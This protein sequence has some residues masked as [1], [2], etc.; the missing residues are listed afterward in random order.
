MRKVLF[1]I[2][3]FFLS[4]CFLDDGKEHYNLED[5]TWEWKYKN[6]QIR[7]SR[8]IVNGY[9]HGLQID[10]YSNG[11]YRF[12]YSMKNGIQDG[13]EYRYYENGILA[14]GGY[15]SNGKADGIY[16]GFYENG[17]PKFCDLFREDE[18]VDFYKD[19]LDELRCKDFIYGLKVFSYP[20]SD[21]TNS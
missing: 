12:I 13:P 16:Y 4:S 1:I 20:E 5:G 17:D 15:M 7:E 3:V 9:E 11:N 2:P 8:T 21:P 19:S 18:P 6:G 14:G 10:Y